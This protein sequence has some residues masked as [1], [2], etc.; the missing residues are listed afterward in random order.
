MTMLGTP[1]H[2]EI[3]VTMITLPLVVTTGGLLRLLETIVTILHLLAPL[4]NW[5]TIVL[6][7]SH[8]HHLLAMMLAPGT[9]PLRVIR[10]ILRAFSGPLLPVIT[11]TASI[12]GP[13][14]LVIGMR[15]RRLLPEDREHPPALHPLEVAMNTIGLRQGII[16]PE[17]D[18]IHAERFLGIT[19]LRSTAGDLLLPHLVD[20]EITRE[21][22][23]L[24]RDIGMSLISWLF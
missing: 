5:T 23:A 10:Y 12:E 4:G 14:L 15:T 2:L 1:H 19:L 16:K 7:V 8:R 9:I 3:L 22:V 21:Q 6:E 24:K 13:L 11:M 17:I 18:V 20:M